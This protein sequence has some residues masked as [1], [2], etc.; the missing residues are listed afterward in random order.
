MLSA[1]GRRS[2]CD[3]VALGS[4]L[5]AVRRR[6]ESRLQS[7][8]PGAIR[9]RAADDAVSRRLAVGAGG[10]ALWLV[11]GLLRAFAGLEKATAFYI[12]N[13]FFYVKMALF[14]VGIR[15]GDHP[16]GDVHQVAARARRAAPSRG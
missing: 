9:R 7:A 8:A 10:G 2:T 14:L 15:A 16:D 1:S 6:T 3:Y 5:G 12:S 4:G 11:T 13:G